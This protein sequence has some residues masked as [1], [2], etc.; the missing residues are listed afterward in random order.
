[1]VIF[2][3]CTVAGTFTARRVSD[4]LV[5]VAGLPLKVTR[6]T[7]AVSLKP[8]PAIQTVESFAAEAGVKEARCNG[9]TTGATGGGGGG[10]VVVV[11]VLVFLQARMDRA[12]AMKRL[13]REK[14][15]VMDIGL[16]GVIRIP[17]R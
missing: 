5:T 9:G 17:E 14:D 12:A 10:G 4:A 6:S 13:V 16:C 15:R 2:P 11:G 3:S 1:M 8:V 7:D